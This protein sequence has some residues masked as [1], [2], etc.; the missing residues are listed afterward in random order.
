MYGQYEL[1]L[2]MV[3]KQEKVYFAPSKKIFVCDGF[4]VNL[5]DS[6][7]AVINQRTRPWRHDVRVP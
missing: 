4:G 5:C 6:I 2:V 1:N 3:L 7:Y